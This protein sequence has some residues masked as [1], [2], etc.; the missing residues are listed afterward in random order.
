M[1]SFL[2]QHDLVWERPAA[3]WLEGIPLANGELGVVAWGDGHPLRLTI[4]HC[5]AWDTREQPVDW[6]RF[7]YRTLRKLIAEG[8]FDEARQVFQFDVFDK[9]KV[10]PMRVQLGRLRFD[11]GQPATSFRARLSLWDAEATG[12]LGF[13]GRSVGFQMWVLQPLSVVA[14]RLTGETDLLRQFT[15]DPRELRTDDEALQRAWGYQ[16]VRSDEFGVPPSGGSGQIPPEGGTPNGGFHYSCLTVPNVGDL[17]VMWH[18][19]KSVQETWCYGTVTTYHD[20]D[21]PR[22]VAAQRLQS[23]HDSRDRLIRQHRRWWHA[24]WEKSWLT[25]PDAEL[26]ALYYIELYKLGCVAQ[27]GKWAPAIQGPWTLDPSAAIPENNSLPPWGGNYVQDLNTQACHWSLYAANRL[28]QGEPMY[29][30][31]ERLMP[32]FQDEC[33]KFYG[34]DGAF[35]QAAIGPNNSHMHGWYTAELWPGNG[36]WVAHMFW[37]HY[38]HSRDE[39][40]LRE[41]AYSFMREFFRMYSGLL[42]KSD[43]GFYHFPCIT[44]PE[45]GDADPR[46]WGSDSAVDLSLFRCLGNALLQSVEILKLDEPLADEWRERLEKLAPLPEDELTGIQILKGVPLSHSHRHFSHLMAIHPL[47]TLTIEDGER[48][49]KLI[50]TSLRWLITK[51]TGEWAGFSYPWAALIS[52]RARRGNMAWHFLR[53]HLSCHISANGFMFDGDPKH[54]GSNEINPD[55]V[56]TLEGGSAAAAI[57]E[58]LLQ[59]WGGVIRVFPAMPHHWRD[60]AFRQLRAEGAFLVSSEL[61]DGTV[62]WVEIISEVGGECRLRNPWPGK[63][64]NLATKEQGDDLVFDAK[65]GGVYIL[66]PHAASVAATPLKFSR[67]SNEKNR[68]GAKARP[69]QL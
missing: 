52:G 50:E 55:N 53:R 49:R 8:R 54:I 62:Q 47:A 39:K 33:R 35:C 67:K 25:I 68:F 30:F 38:L 16:P 29:R 43:D 2:R 65:A 3:N 32:R 21:D 64:I 58:M 41:R 51:G 14:I 63:E 17:V 10:R 31:Y 40:F 46:A 26:E 9:N 23:V 59:T 57:M 27:P 37:L 6:N 7:N 36:P 4:D 69:W 44:S 22:V 60:A 19:V 61:R 11:F 12:E 18:M 56:A 13:D 5:G 42:E 24:Y 28:D 66:H 34:W 20:G 48:E 45:W 1:S 15:A